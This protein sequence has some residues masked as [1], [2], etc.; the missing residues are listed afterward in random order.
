MF[1]SQAHSLPCSTGDTQ[2]LRALCTRFGSHTLPGTA[3]RLLQMK[4][5]NAKRT[6]GGRRTLSWPVLEVFMRAI[7]ADLRA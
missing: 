2:K 7:D 3:A 5:R 1:V 6:R 4:Q